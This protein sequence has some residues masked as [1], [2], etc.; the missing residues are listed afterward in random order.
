MSLGR[1]T[2]EERDSRLRSL[3]SERYVCVNV[4]CAYVVCLCVCVCAYVN[5]CTHVWRRLCSSRGGI[6]VCMNINT[7]V[8]VYASMYHT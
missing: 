5:N 2:E 3:K 6:F 7:C 1:I 8:C 4:F